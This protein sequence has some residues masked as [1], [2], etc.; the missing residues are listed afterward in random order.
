MLAEGRVMRWRLGHTHTYTHMYTHTYT[1]MYT[2]MY[3]YT[4]LLEQCFVV[5]ICFALNV[6][7]HPNNL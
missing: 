2:H 6:E 5:L 7:Q 1:H 4:Q 3:T